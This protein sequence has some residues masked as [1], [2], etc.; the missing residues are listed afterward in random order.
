LSEKL[1]VLVALKKGFFRF[2]WVSGGPLP[3]G[4]EEKK[5]SFKGTG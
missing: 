4:D 5:V 2:L 1:L 3:K